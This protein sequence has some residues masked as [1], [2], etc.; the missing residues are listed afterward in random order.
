MS[1]I[2]DFN[3]A[4]VDFSNFKDELLSYIGGDLVN[5]ETN[6]SQLANLFDQY[7]GFS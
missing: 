7:S 6:D 1:F 3:S 5:I 2:D 4:N